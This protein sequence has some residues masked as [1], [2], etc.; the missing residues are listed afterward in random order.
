MLIHNYNKKMTDLIVLVI[1]LLTTACT[2]PGKPDPTE[3][4]ITSYLYK[5]GFVLEA[6][7]KEE[8]SVSF[9]LLET[10]NDGSQVLGTLSVLANEAC[11]FLLRQEEKLIEVNSEALEVGQRVEVA[12]TKILE[13]EIGQGY[14]DQVVILS[15][16]AVKRNEP[17]SKTLN[18]PVSA[19]IQSIDGVDNLLDYSH[20]IT[21]IIEKPEAFRGQIVRWYLS[22]QGLVWLQD[23]ESYRLRKIEDLAVD[24]TVIVLPQS[25][26]V[27][28]GKMPEQEFIEELII[29]P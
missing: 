25:K 13:Q 19:R 9:K 28:N 8:G 15:P 10:G 4:T 12:L 14:A 2:F 17:L 3:T 6:P 24:Q 11:R 16:S 21:L 18:P 22:N 29:V 1:I 20:Q 23:G 27:W 7:I 26:W 5:N